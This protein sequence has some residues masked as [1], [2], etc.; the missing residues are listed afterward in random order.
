MTNLMS[1]DE[2]KSKFVGMFVLGFLAGKV[3]KDEGFNL[4][5]NVQFNI[6]GKN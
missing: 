5:P 1:D 2:K 6:L 3:A 4:V